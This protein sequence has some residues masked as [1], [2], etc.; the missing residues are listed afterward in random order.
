MPQINAG[1]EIHAGSIPGLCFS[2]EIR[3]VYDNTDTAEPLLAFCELT[4]GLDRRRL[5]INAES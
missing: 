5:Q 2:M 1:S 3:A 4:P